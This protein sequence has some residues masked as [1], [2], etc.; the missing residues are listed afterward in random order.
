MNIGIICDVSSNIPKGFIAIDQDNGQLGYVTNDDILD[1]IIEII[2]DSDQLSLPIEEQINDK[3][4]LREEQIDKNDNHYLI[5]FNYIL[6]HPWR[7]LG[8]RYE[9]GKI[10]DVLNECQNY[11][12]E[13]I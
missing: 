11:L 5:S 9:N 12:D 13:I 10:E 4:I 7:I 1:E 8:T 6:P 2:L 3:I